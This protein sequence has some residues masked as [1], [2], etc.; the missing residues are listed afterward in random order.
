MKN[1]FTQILILAFCSLFATQLFANTVIVKGYIQYSNGTAA[2]NRTVKISVDSAACTVQHTKTT[3]ANGYY[4]DTISCSVDI[5]IVRI[6]TEDCN[7]NVL[8]NTPHVAA[9]SITVENNFTLSCVPTI[10]PV[11]S[12]GFRDSVAGTTIK[13]YSNAS[14]S[15]NDTITSRTWYFGDSSVIT[16]NLTNLTYQFPKPGT[17]NVC[18]A[19][20]TAK[21]CTNKACYT[22]TIPA[23]APP[24]CA[25]YFRDTIKGNTVNF[26]AMSS[27]STGDSVVSRSW[28]FGDSSTSA[29]GSTATNPT[30][31]YAKAGTYNVCLYTKTASGCESHFC[32]SV[33][34]AP[35]PPVICATYFKDSVSGN[36]VK[37]YGAVSTTDSVISHTWYFGD[38]SNTSTLGSSDMN[39]THQFAKAGTYNVCF[40]TKTAKGCESHI[41]N[42]VTIAVPPPP[43]VCY[44]TFRDTVKGNTVNFYAVN[45]VST[46]DSVISRTWF[47][48]D[49]TTA[50]AGSIQTN[51]IHQYA[52]AGTYTVCLYSKT[53]K[54]C[55]SK[56]CNTVTI[57]PPPPPVC[58]TYFR[59][60]VNGSTVNFYGLNSVST[61]DS[62]VSRTWIFGDN[63]TATGSSDINPTHQY[64][65]AGTYNVCL[66]TKTVKGCESHICSNVTIV[67]PP[68][69]VFATNFRDSVKGAIVSFY[70]L[71]SVSTGDSVVS[72]TWI[73][74]DST[75]PNTVGSN[76]INPI[77]QYAKGGTYNVCLYTKTAK[78]CESKM[79]N[80]VTVVIAPPPPVICSATF[81]D[82]V[83]GYNVKFIGTATA[84]D[85]IISRYWVF[86]DAT[87]STTVGSTTNDPVHQYAKAGAYN[88]C[89]YIKTARGCESHICT[90]VY[91]APPPAMVCNTSFRDSVFG[92]S[93]V[94][95]STGTAPTNDSIISR[96]W[97]FGD[98]STLTGNS[99][100]ATHQYA[101]PGT[102]NVCLYTKT[103][104]GCESKMCNTVTIA[105]PPPNTNCKPQFTSEKIAE[106]AIRFN[107]SSTWVPDGDSI[108][109]RRWVFGDGSSID[110][111]TASPVKQYS[112]PGI[113]TVCMKIK[114]A[115][116]CENEYCVEILVTD[117]IPV[118]NNG[119]DYV[120]I[121]SIN[122]NPV[123]TQMT[124][125][126]WSK[127]N[128]VDAE[129]AIYDIFGVKK[130]SVKK[131]LLQ[132]NN[133]TTIATGFLSNGLYF[134]RVTSSYGV[135]SRL[136]YKF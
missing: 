63:G 47:F 50:N 7:G 11:C 42:T 68:P 86:G 105:P 113:F 84:N 91:V 65:K 75:T 125:V 30:H 5:R 53:A 128:N 82:S 94:V 2:A 23:P 124:T 89:F 80:T 118:A 97:I 6:S 35:P 121:L 49:S 70:G 127:N 98:T 15:S 8:I 51:P 13:F 99:I 119:S 19:I 38:S 100:Y 24:V 132:G 131:T 109:E 12:A 48:G 120:N 66:Y 74:G 54:G 95:A 55:E 32:N 44:T 108:I 39:P 25:T 96:T 16:G 3:N 83:Q 133:T 58:A 20:Q 61:G 81:R 129:V 101:K 1:T 56:M 45:G 134:L 88:V 104:K 78:G 85:S 36:T 26:Y 27:V 29:A 123:S 103:A 52:K 92:N 59:D 87:S 110:G 126:I 90:N 102:Y 71:N 62:V 93:I 21:G 79:C 107:S 73:F 41:C 46:G 72:R 64:A 10:A 57:A 22:I 14:T 28:Y 60:T 69:P 18:L 116:G 136:F 122:P 17:Y 31:Q 112:F 4:I 111:N 67:P 106:R 33:V 135:Q 117:S 130:W 77:H 114:T 40:Y 76:A 37:F 9:G 43:P 34:I 115:K